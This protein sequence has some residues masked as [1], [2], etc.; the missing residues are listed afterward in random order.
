MTDAGDSID[1]SVQSF[2][3]SLVL[4][5]SRGEAE[6]WWRLERT[7]RRLVCWWC[8]KGQ[9]PSQDVDDV[10]QEVFVALAQALPRYEHESFRGFLWTIVRNK[11]RDYWRTKRTQLAV[12]GKDVEE[13]LDDVETES[14]RSVGAV[15]QATK[16]V[17]DAI[18][19]LVKGQFSE[20][21]WQAFWFFAV[22]GRPAAEVATALGISRNQVYLA[23]S[24]ILRKIHLEFRASESGPAT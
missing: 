17:V 22:E 23:K 2:T 19:Q 20:Q 21:D 1:R 3:T 4:R 7:Y 12:E 9:I 14:N 13:L 10:V 11:I 5:A 15:D 24:R 8:A 16:L 6:A 18:V